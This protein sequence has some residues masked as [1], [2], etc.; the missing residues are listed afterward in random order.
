MKKKQTQDIFNFSFVDILATTIGVLIFIMVLVIINSSSRIP[1]NDVSKD[2]VNEMSK[3]ETQKKDIE[4]IQ[5][6]IKRFKSLIS[7]HENQNYDI[8]KAAHKFDDNLHKQQVLNMKLLRKFK[9]LKKNEKQ[10]IAN[11]NNKKVELDNNKNE[12]DNIKKQPEIKRTKVVFR[13]PEE[14][15][16]SKKPI[17]F[18][19]ANKQ[20]YI[21]ADHGELNKKSYSISLIANLIIISR[22]KKAKGYT[23]N[24]I[25]NP[26]SSFFKYHNSSKYYAVFFVR[27]D[28]F[29]FYRK[30]REVFWENNWDCIWQGELSGNNFLINK[31]SRGGS[32]T[33]L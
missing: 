10:L 11:L 6:A 31:N 29:M 30:I 21:L 18:E 9:V 13:I 5:S 3:T 23:I 19:C 27:P 2:L 22:K 17:Y 4:N 20:L 1:I 15:T 7:Y 24:K 32:E 33:I 16:T 14:R 25:Q 28:S 12:L 26:N 8:S